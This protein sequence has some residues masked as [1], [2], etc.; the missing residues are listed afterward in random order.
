MRKRLLSELGVMQG[1]LLPK[2]KDR[3]QAFPK[4]NWSLEFNIAK[5]LG[6]KFIEFIFDYEAFIENPLFSKKGLKKIQFLEKVH[7]IKIRS[8]CAD[9]FMEK[10]IYQDGTSYLTNKIILRNLIKNCKKVGIKEIIIPCVDKSSLDTTIKIKKA[11]IFLKSLKYYLKKNNTNLTLET[12]L[13][14]TKF[15]NLINEI[16]SKNIKINYDIGNSASLG[17]NPIVEFKKYGHYI[18]NIHIKDRQM[19]GPSCELGSGDANFELI[20]RLLKN[21]NEKLIILQM[22]RDNE[23]ISILKKQLKFLR[24]KFD[25]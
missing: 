3:F 18:T 6:F 2:Y 17:Y 24:D 19:N 22:F 10:P 13:S 4:Y 15:S 11:K 20:F 9:F 8:I 21:M 25:G 7:K 1:R 12:D 14:P 23:G 5:K 16:G